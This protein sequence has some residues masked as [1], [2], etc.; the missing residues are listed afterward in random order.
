MY[1]SAIPPHHDNWSLLPVEKVR[2]KGRDD[3]AIVRLN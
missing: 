3:K 2:Q 1:H